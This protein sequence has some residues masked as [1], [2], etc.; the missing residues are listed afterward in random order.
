[1]ETFTRTGT[2]V[3][4]D[5]LAIVGLSMMNIR[6]GVYIY[7]PI[8]YFCATHDKITS[9]EQM[10]VPVLTMLHIPRWY[11]LFRIA[12]HWCRCECNGGDGGGSGSG[13]G[14]DAD[15]ND[16]Y[17]CTQT[18]TAME[19]AVLVCIVSLLGFGSVLCKEVEVETI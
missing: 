15:N 5:K 7:V 19:A 8:T 1:M 9:I 18:R 12:F 11:S 17:A 13:C 2:A 14:G 3:P 16:A 4:L 6:Q 10:H